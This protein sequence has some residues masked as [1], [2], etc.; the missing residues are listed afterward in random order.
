MTSYAIAWVVSACHIAC[1]RGVH[2]AKGFSLLCSCIWD[3][4]QVWP[5][6]YSYSHNRALMCKIFHCMTEH[7]CLL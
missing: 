1:S 5:Y 3:S 6:Q 2:V 7:A 4:M